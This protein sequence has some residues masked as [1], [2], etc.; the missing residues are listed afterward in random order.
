MQ[1]HRKYVAMETQLF[2]MGREAFQTYLDILEWSSHK[3]ILHKEDS[4][5]NEV[6]ALFGAAYR[7]SVAEQLVG[8]VQEKLGGVRHSVWTNLMCTAGECR[9][10]TSP[11]AT[12]SSTH[13]NSMG[14][15]LLFTNGCYLPPL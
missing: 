4:L 14:P 5:A 15:E 12:T 10:S 7:A 8:Q 2:A 1:T 3:D 6:Q 11:W 9:V 13:L